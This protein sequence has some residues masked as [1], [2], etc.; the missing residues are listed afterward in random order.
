M[1]CIPPKE[2]KEKF[3]RE[4]QIIST[5]ICKISISKN[6]NTGF[7]IKFLTKDENIFCLMTNSHFISDEMINNKQ[8][9]NFEYNKG[10]INKIITLDI[11]ER[12]IKRFKDLKSIIIEILPTDKIQE[13]YFLSINLDYHNN[14]NLSELN[15]K[16]IIILG[17]NEK[18]N[19][20]YAEG[21]IDKIK[22]NKISHTINDNN[23]LKGSPIFM[24]NSWDI[25]GINK[26]SYKKK[27]ENYAYLIGTI[28]D[29]FK[30]KSKIELENGGYYFGQMENNLPN[31]KGKYYFSN[32]EIY[33]GDV[34]NNKFEGNGKFI[35]ENGEYYI[36]QWKNNLRIGK[37][38][39]Y[40]KSNKIKYDGDFLDDKFDGNGKY[41]FDDGEY[42]EGEFKQG[43]KNGKGKLYSKDKNIIYDGDFINGN[44]EGNGKYIYENGDYYEG[45]F[46]NG[47][48]HGKGKEVDKDDNIICEGEWFY[49]EFKESN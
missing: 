30:E 29:Y 36:G 41:Y 46:K 27:S 18:G 40:Y 24:K 32:G 48:C 31:G 28:Y 5:S 2:E 14:N 7:L 34:I 19:L 25:I 11:K 9:I 17:F 42:Y 12:Y 39:L 47:L 44:Y 21:K 15:D 22:D 13:N 35:Y 37:G 8:Q 33:E 23:I 16:K 1:G 26:G 49:D 4:L 6:F 20:S 38:I 10:K 45:E 43:E 3:P